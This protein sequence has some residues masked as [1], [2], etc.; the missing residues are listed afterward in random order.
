MKNIKAG[1]RMKTRNAREVRNST[2]PFGIPNVREA[3]P[4][5]W[6]AV[7]LRDIVGGNSFGKCEI[8]NTPFRRMAFPGTA[9]I[10]GEQKA[11]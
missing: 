3:V 11:K 9:T 7:R 5:E 4:G 2:A 6:S 1:V 10:I 8:Q